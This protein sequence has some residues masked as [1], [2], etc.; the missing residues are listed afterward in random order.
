VTSRDRQALRLGAMAILGAV[1]FLRVLPWSVRLGVTEFA[2]L[3]ARRTL[4]A[5][6][7]ADLASLPQLEDSATV[8]TQA[9]V[10]LA[11]RL[12]S[13]HGEG[14]AQA[15]L[16]GRL[17]YLA[18]TAHMK[19]EEVAPVTDSL[20]AGNLRRLTVDAV[21][22]GDVHGAAALMAALTTDVTALVP[23]RLRVVAADPA[24]SSRVPEVLRL[25][26]R[27]TAWALRSEDDG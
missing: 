24:S 4:L 9:V 25:E 14:E 11:P 18:T 5:R 20:T 27:L 6:T 17:A 13:G 23:I 26:V 1:M 10:A 3:G 8:L 22:E 7:R 21:F 16:Q 12:L 2:T 19:L 15:E